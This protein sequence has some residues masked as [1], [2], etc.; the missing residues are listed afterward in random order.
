MAPSLLSARS[1]ARLAG[2]VA[3]KREA[4]KRIRASVARDRARWLGELT[5]NGD[6]AQIRKR[7]RGFCP[8]RGRLRDGAGDL[9]DSDN[10]AD[11]L[12]KHLE[13]VQWA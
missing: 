9:V 1:Q 12:A 10:R 6:W 13:A 8:A 2:D 11:A 4:A 7:R 5:Q 3:R